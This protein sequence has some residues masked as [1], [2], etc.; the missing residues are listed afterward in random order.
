MQGNVIL[1]T[2]AKIEKNRSTGTNISWTN[3]FT[4]IKVT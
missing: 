4:Y 2:L 1:F 3:R